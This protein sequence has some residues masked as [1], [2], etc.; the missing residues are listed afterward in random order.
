MKKNFR[1]GYLLIT[2]LLFGWIVFFCIPVILLCY[3][4]LHEGVGAHARFS[5]LSNYGK[6]MESSIFQLAAVNTFCFLG[7]AIPLILIFAYAIAILLEAF[8]RNSIVLKS[9]MLLT[10][11][12]PA[13]AVV[14]L[15]AETAQSIH[16]MWILVAL[17][18]WKNT[19]YSAILIW[20]GLMTIPKEQYESA[21]MD[22][23]G[24]F[25]CFQKITLPQMWYTTYFTILFSVMN[26]FK[27]FREILLIWGKH[28][29]PKQYM[30]QHYISNSFEQLSLSRLSTASIL[31]FAVILLANAWGYH[32]VMRRD[33]RES[34]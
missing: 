23:A 5:G 31:L 18:L 17:Y 13:G 19:G 15:F 11:L 34:L 28:P 2:P 12:M 30:I 24:S 7:V 32:Y 20:S 6:L 10:Y 8:F 21:R 14:T 9:A 4:S 22:G 33:P 16:G 29:D 25:Y 1:I 3:N 27:G 26:A